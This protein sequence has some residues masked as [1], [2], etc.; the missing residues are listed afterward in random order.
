MQIR[1]TRLTETIPNTRLSPEQMAVLERK[2][3]ELGSNLP[4]ALRAIITEY[5]R[6]H[7]QEKQEQ[8]A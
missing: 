1:K 6:E 8:A 4:V 5:G 7:Y 2:A 3:D